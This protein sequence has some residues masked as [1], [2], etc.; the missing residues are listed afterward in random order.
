MKKNK[1]E[2]LLEQLTQKVDT[3]HKEID[4]R[5]DNIEKVM[6]AQEINLKIHI[7]RSDQLEDLVNTIRE[8][9]LKPLHR[10]VAQVEGVFKFI[11]IVSLL[12]GIIGGLAKLFAF[13]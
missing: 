10:H 11:G 1:T 13:I 12:T 4:L 3:Q 9:E 6:I 2:S 8:Q 5:L 7:K